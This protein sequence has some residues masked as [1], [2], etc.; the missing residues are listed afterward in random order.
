[1][2]SAAVMSVLQNPQ[3]AWR[4]RNR[5]FLARLISILADVG[6]LVAYNDGTAII[7]IE[8]VVGVRPEIDDIADSGRK[9]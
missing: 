1:M 7:E 8:M 2:A 4:E 6:I 3:G 9:G 5:H